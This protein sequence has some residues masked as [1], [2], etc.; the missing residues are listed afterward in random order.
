MKIAIV[1]DLQPDLELLYRK[2]THYFDAQKLTCEIY[3]FKSGEAFLEFFSPHT[4]DL[5]FLDI[6]MKALTGMDVAKHI[7][8]EDKECKIIFLTTSEEFSRQSYAVHAVYYLIKPIDDKEFLQAME[9]CNITPNYDVPYLSVSIGGI[10]T[11]IDTSQI[12]YIDFKDRACHIH[13]PSRII[14]VSG[15][16]SEITAPLQEDSRFL[17]CIRGIMV[18]MQ[19]IT[20]LVGTYF[21]LSNG[22]SI[23]INLRKKKGIAQTYHQY[24]FQMI[25]CL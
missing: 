12:L 25:C 17:V 16:F 2:L 10:L 6:Y 4:F 22:E 20:D 23:P 5:V 1:E 21:T 3:S 13:L 8:R 18:N 9:F 11:D 24:I 14:T 19:H 15:T 7:Y